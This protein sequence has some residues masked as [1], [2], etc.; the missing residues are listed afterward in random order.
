MRSLRVAGAA[1]AIGVV[2]LSA[3]HRD[4][5]PQEIVP[6]V[7]LD[8]EVSTPVRG[9]G[10]PPPPDVSCVT[11]VRG[12]LGQV[13]DVDLSYGN[14]NWA[15]GAY[16]Y[17]WTGPSP[18][19]HWSAYRFD[20]SPV[21][22]NTQV[23]SATFTAQV[24]WNEKSSAVRAHR[25]LVDWDELTATWAT[26]GGAASW[27]PAVVASF[28]PIGV[29][30]KSIDVTPLVQAWVS[31][32]VPNHGL[33]LEEDPVMLHLFFSSDASQVAQRPAL[34]VCYTANGPCAGKVNGDPCDD[35]NACTLGETC[36]GTQCIG[37]APKSCDPLD[38]CHDA[39]V[40]D[41]VTGVCSDP[42]KPDGSPCTD[43]DACTQSDACVGA[44]CVGSTVSC[45]DANPCN[46]VETC[47]SATGCVAGTTLNCDDQSA[48]TTDACDPA[49]GCTHGAVN[50]DDESLCTTDACDPATGC[51]HATVSCDDSN[52][53]TADGCEAAVGCTHTTVS[54]D[55]S[56]ACTN[57]GC[58]PATGCTH[59]AVDS[60]DSLACTVDSCV[61]GDDRHLVRC[62]PGQPCSQSFCSSA[63][64]QDPQFA[65]LCQ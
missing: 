28:D 42:P 18:Y 31:G 3:C 5:P 4:G 17:T 63:Q 65:W 10:T 51:T 59:A 55:D 50:C 15:S 8:E 9:P 13:W 33:L 35:G 45:D 41:P 25:V 53:C 21:P 26:F 7:V 38:D 27:D 48:C 64:A 6:D 23:V 19:D 43:G 24:S 11:I 36:L 22:P 12:A 49:S 2:L 14:G 52:A 56:D 16:P 44:A 60:S 57:D 39:G 46:G 29:G 61:G 30:S 62:A 58:E 20:L 37:G 40:C 34:T 54:C 32:A 1:G 47:D